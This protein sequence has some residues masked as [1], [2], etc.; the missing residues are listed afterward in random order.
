MSTTAKIIAWGAAIAIA[1]TVLAATPSE[2]RRHRSAPKDPPVDTTANPPPYVGLWAQTAEACKAEKHTDKAPY[3][4]RAKRLLQFETDCGLSDVR[5]AG[6]LWTANATCIV[7]GDHQRHS[8][9]MTVEGDALT[10]GWDSPKGD[11]LVRCKP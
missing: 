9:M 5:N 1:G 3:E 10:F 8:L 6:T 4:L 7:Q 2:A 11:K